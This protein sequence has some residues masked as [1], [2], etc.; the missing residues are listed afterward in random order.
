MEQTCFEDFSDPFIE[1]KLFLFLIKF[2]NVHP[3]IPN[4][5][6]INI[7]TISHL[8]TP[9]AMTTQAIPANRPID[10]NINEKRSIQSMV[11]E[12]TFEKYQNKLLVLSLYNKTSAFSKPEISKTETTEC[13]HRTEDNVI[14]PPKSS[15]LTPNNNIPL[16][17]TTKTVQTCF[18]QA[19]L[20]HTIL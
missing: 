14:L 19:I 11:T 20:I 12:K 4:L 2:E 13:V 5:L 15:N 3:K 10:H 1:Q 16:R 17:V 8:E 18:T 9:A 7:E 6:Q